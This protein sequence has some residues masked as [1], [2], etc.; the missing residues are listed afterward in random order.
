MH[1]HVPYVITF[2][3][4][5]PDSKID[6]SLVH[7]GR[8]D[9]SSGFVPPAI[10]SISARG[11]ATIPVALMIY[12][13]EPLLGIPNGANPLVLMYE[14]RWYYAT[15]AQSNPLAQ[16]PNVLTIRFA[17]NIDLRGRDQAIITGLCKFTHPV[18]VL[19][20]SLDLFH[21]LHANRL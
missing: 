12:P 9:S 3:L 20:L 7:V 13:N 16:E 5:N 18:Y 1:S 2:I 8:V 14:P 4:T 15:I 6:S 11:T 10:M 21:G 19:C 17:T